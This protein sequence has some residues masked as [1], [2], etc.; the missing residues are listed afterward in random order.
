M[1]EYSEQQSYSAEE[2]ISILESLLNQLRPHMGKIVLA[3]QLIDEITRL[4]ANARLANSSVDPA[5]REW[6]SAP[7]EIDSL[8]AKVCNFLN[9]QQQNNV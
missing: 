5:M 7:G 6:R 2:A 9:R 1:S 3:D 4:L 8:R